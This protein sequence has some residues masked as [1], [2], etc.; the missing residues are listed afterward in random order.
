MTFTRKVLLVFLLALL[1]LPLQ[2][3]ILHNI[4]P[5][6]DKEYTVRLTNGDVISGFI[7]QMITDRNEGDG[8][9][10]QTPLGTAVIYESQISNI[11][12][13]ESAYRHSHRVFLLPTAEGIKD[14]YFIGNFEL[15]FLYAGAGIGDWFSITAGRSIIPGIASYQQI[16]VV[17]AKFTVF[18]QDFDTLGRKLLIAVGGNYGWANDANKLYH[19]YGVG[20]FKLSR[21]SL[22]AN[23]FYKLG[24]VDYY[25]LS[26]GNS[27]LIPMR[28][29]NYAWG[30]GLGMDTQLPTWESVH[31]IGEL[32]NNDIT[33]PSKTG[34]LLGLRICNTAFSADFGLTVF[35]QPFLA[36]FVSFTW[37]PF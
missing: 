31:V 18:N 25:N 6:R 15:L 34:I 11:R 22:T 4:S 20:T 16:S 13:K 32:W 33:S 23:V 7:T 30:I 21:T 17:N 28:Y 10:M 29:N 14:N 26:F 1:N 9:E 37:T 3:G 12:L 2:A 24:S 27:G 19:L 36:P 5:S 35:T 8:I